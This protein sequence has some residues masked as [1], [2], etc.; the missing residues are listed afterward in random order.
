MA[1][2]PDI[3]AS[4]EAGGRV[5]R[6]GALR[7]AGYL[8]GMGLGAVAA[9]LLLRHLSV[10]DWGR[11][12][13]VMAMVAIANGLSEGGLTV[14]GQQAWTNAADAAARR[15]LL[16]NLIG[17][18]LVIT[19]SVVLVMIAFAIVAGY[20]ET[21]VLGAVIAG[22]GAVLAVTAT[23]IA[24]P[25]T[26]DLRLGAMTIIDL[27]TQ[28]VTFVGIAI[29]V[30]LGATL[31]PFFAVQIA[32]GLC[33]T[34]MAVAI[35]Q[36]GLP[37]LPRFNWDVWRPLLYIAAPVAFSVVINQIYLRVL[38]I[39][40]SLMDTARQTGLFG[41]AYRVNDVFVGLPVFIVGAA[42]P[43]LAHAGTRDE[44]RLAYAL[45]RLAEVALVVAFFIAV[46]TTVAAEPI[47]RILG[48]ARY[49][50]A[51]PVLRVQCW[52]LVGAS[53]TQVW[54][55]GL[56]AVGR[57]RSLIVSNSVAL[58]LAIILGIVLIPPLHAQGASIAAVAGEL[59]LA[60]A[61][62]TMLVRAR[63]SAR[64]HAARALRACAAAGIG[65]ACVLLPFPRL[66]DGII[67]ALVFAGVAVAV[68]AVP[69]EVTHALLRRRVAG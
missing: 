39:L 28:V 5:I 43:V 2:E 1:A 52:A 54:S 30:G 56:V 20:P 53:L 69:S 66:V 18:R 14:T 24:L 41:T 51:G 17:M 61:N 60:A 34:A 58:V 40:V 21:V 38:V 42:F 10:P 36:R 33:T 68:R 62:L 13:T 8:A 65:V 46:G 6:G 47:V 59:G 22:S 3:L 7:G 37:V 55:L 16:A 35:T 29:L 25:L 12:V 67:A 27:T 19:G 15:R 63:P 50:A 48:G 11:Y 49:A 45:Q 26:V 9:V 57:Q 32:A 4:R 31:E 64:P 44:A 23:T